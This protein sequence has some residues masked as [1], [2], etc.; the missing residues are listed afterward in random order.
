MCGEIVNRQ[1]VDQATAPERPAILVN[2]VRNLIGRS[3]ALGV[4]TARQQAGLEQVRN[5][6]GLDVAISNALLTNNDFDH[7]FEPG[8]AP[9]PV[10]NELNLVAGFFRVPGD[11][12]CHVIGT[13]RNRGRFAWHIYSGG[14]QR[15]S[16][17]VATISS[18]RSA[19]TRP[20]VLPSTM[21]AGEQA[22]LPRQ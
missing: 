2:Q 16:F 12:Y 11:C 20:K 14:H 4:L 17:I 7:R 6:R 9:G 5:V 13:D 21:M 15:A 10:S 8:R 22:Q 3:D 19:L 18:K 1:W